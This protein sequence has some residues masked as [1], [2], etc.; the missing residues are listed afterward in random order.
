MAVTILEAAD[1]LGLA[2]RPA[3]S[4]YRA[5]CPFCGDTKF[6]LYLNPQKDAWHCFRCGE[7]GGVRDL[8]QKLGRSPGERPRAPH[9]VF[10]LTQDDMRAAGFRGAVD[11][12]GL[13][14]R[15]PRYARACADWVWRAW[16][17]YERRRA[18]AQVVLLRA[19][20]ARKG[21]EAGAE[22]CEG[23]AGWQ[24]GAGSGAEGSAERDGR[25]HVS[26]CR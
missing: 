8:L 10:R 20:E 12:K 9:P 3:G 17:E 5:C 13:F 23:G 22:L 25:G 4:E 15:D 18:Q 21:E 24:G 16:C 2:V 26:A 14:A 19:L 1:S 6:H 7:G 11:W